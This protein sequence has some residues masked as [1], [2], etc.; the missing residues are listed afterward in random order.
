[1][2][3]TLAAFFG[4][5]VHELLLQSEPITVLSP[6]LRGE[7]ERV[8]PGKAARVRKQMLTAIED[9]QTFLDQYRELERIMSAPLR[10]KL[11]EERPLNNVVDPVELAEDTAAEERQRLGLGDQPVINLR[12]TLETEVGLRIF[13]GD[14]PSPVA[15]LYDFVTA[16]GC[17]LYINRNHPPER[18]RV[19]MVHEWGHGIVDRHKP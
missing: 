13:Y 19:S 11:P 3:I 7:I 16:L 6:H 1:A 8:H 18:R 12:G 5:P 15:G 2:I 9:F 17:C 10:S 4:R 14:L